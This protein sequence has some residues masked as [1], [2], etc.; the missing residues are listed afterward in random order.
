[1]DRSGCGARTITVSSAW[2]LP[3][4]RTILRSASRILLIV[5]G[6]IG[7]AI[8]AAGA[9]YLQRDITGRLAEILAR[10]TMLRDR[11][12]TGL[13]DGLA[14]LNAG[15]YTQS[16]TPETPLIDATADDEIGQVA[17]PVL[18]GV[19]KRVTPEYLLESLIDPSRR[20]AEGFA[21]TSVVTRDGEV[22]DG[23][24]VRETPE[25]LTLRLAS[26]EVR[27]FARKD[28]E[29]VSTSAVSAMPPMGEVLT[30]FELRDVLAYLA[31]L[32]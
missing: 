4:A 9:W 14:A 7:I 23:I 26:G 30:P 8:A 29:K 13:N 5:V 15:D 22:T 24:R 3:A 20:I 16:T 28:V 11:C 32:K 31:S 12:V 10:L 25:E 17:W 21:T 27:K 18:A 6:A 1:M 2:E 19:G